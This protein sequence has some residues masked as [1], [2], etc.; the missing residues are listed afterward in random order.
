MNNFS[1]K[2]SPKIKWIWFA[3]YLL[4]LFAARIIEAF[5]LISYDSKIIFDMF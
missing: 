5:I 3:I 2:G 4:P 1:I